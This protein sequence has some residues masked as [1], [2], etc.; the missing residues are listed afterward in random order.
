MTDLNDGLIDHNLVTG[1]Y[2]YSAVGLDDLGA[3]E[4]TLVTIVQ[5]V[6]G[7]VGEFKDE[8]E[9]CLKEVVKSC[10]LSPRAENLMIRLTDFSNDVQELHGFKLLDS[11]NVDD[12]DDILDIRGATALFDASENAISATAD[13]G[14]QLIQ[15]DF[16]VN[17]IVVIATDGCDN[18]STLNASHVKEALQNAMKSECLESILTILVGVGIGR[19]PE[20]KTSLDKFK[21]DAGLTQFVDIK[22]ADANTLAKLAK[23]ISKSISATSQALGSGG[24]SQE[25]SGPFLTF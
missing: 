12:Y 5:D 21:S 8:M 15:N 18:L 11:C 19:Y 3:T 17:A 2:N 7:S 6:S 13:Y 14:K 25:L 1:S 9:K 23:F 24:T 10:K 20:V 4:Y 16:A 22:N